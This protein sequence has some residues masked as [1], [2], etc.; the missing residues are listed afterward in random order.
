MAGQAYPD[1]RDLDAQRHAAV[2]A[3]LQPSS[4]S[5]SAERKI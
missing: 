1:A 3:F 2:A 5:A 4:V